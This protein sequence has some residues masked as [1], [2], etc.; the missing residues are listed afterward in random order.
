M[1]AVILAGG[2]GTRLR[3][4]TTVLPKP[5]VPVGD[6]P[7]VELILQQLSH[8]GIRRVDLCVSHLGGLIHAY[9]QQA[10]TLPADM[11]VDF[12][13]EAE[14]LGTAGAL[15]LVP[16]LDGAFLAMNG[17]VLT[18]LDYGAMLAHHAEQEAALTIAVQDQSVDVP[19]GVI[20]RDG[21]RIVGFEEKPVLR[22]EASMGVYAYDAAALRHLPDGVCQFPDLVMRL[23][24]AGERVVAFRTDAAW[25]DI[26][27]LDQ[28]EL[29]TQALIERR[30]QFLPA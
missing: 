23:I 8:H 5:L 9:L 17:D 16:D 30:E 12:R 18:S 15:K 22:Y 11:R 25:Y 26:G 10:H 4:Y 6:R 7:I 28:H 29:A 14:P 19:L 24:E 27:T 3:P 20:E 1:R 2:L 13:W 21:A